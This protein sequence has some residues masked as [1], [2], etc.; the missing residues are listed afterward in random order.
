MLEGQELLSPMAH[1]RFTTA[2][3]ESV[4]HDVEEKEHLHQS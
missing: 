4:V 1:D 3:V 2:V